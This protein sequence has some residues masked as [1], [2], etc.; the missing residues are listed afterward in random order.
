MRVKPSRNLV[1]TTNGRDVEQMKYFTYP[2]SIITTDGGALE[3]VH[4]H[5]KKA[6]GPIVPLYPVWKN[7]YISEPKFGCGIKKSSQ[8]YCM[9]VERGN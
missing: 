8:S 7:K 5:I 1:L 9:G 3:G 6:N 4:S 2:G